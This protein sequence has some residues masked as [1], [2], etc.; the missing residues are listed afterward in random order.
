MIL[1]ALTVYILATATFI[2]YERRLA[3]AER[4][5]ETAGRVGLGLLIFGAALQCGDLVVIA[6]ETPRLMA[7]H[8][9]VL[10]ALCL[11]WVLIGIAFIGKLKVPLLGVVIAPLAAAMTLEVAVA[12]TRP[13]VLPESMGMLKGLGVVAHAFLGFA[14]YASFFAAA[15]GAAL[16]LLQ[17]RELRL[18]R[19]GPL[20][21]YLPPLERSTL[22][23]RLGVKIGVPL[24]A[25]AAVMAGLMLRDAA[26]PAD[27][28]ADPAI[29]SLGILWLYAAILLVFGRHYGWT[30]RH[31]A[32]LVFLLGLAVMGLQTLLVFGGNFHSFPGN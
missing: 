11:G 30:R 32:I 3:R 25:A 2:F 20:F 13:P 1:A 15:L 21:D 12:A 26:T 29:H 19:L 22:I 28:A 10:N 31:Q 5:V 14:G 7:A 6:M 23:M 27:L 17:D 24:L 8:A 4:A 9:S 18:K 16:Y